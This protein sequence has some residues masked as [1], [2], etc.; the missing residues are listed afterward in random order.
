ML[1]GTRI[2]LNIAIDFTASNGHPDDED[3]LHNRDPQKNQY[4]QVIR[5][6][7]KLLHYYDSSKCVPTYGFGAKVK[8]FEGTWHA[9]ALNGDIYDPECNGIKGVEN[10]YRKALTATDFAGPTNFAGICKEI[11]QRLEMLPIS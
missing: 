2:C 10:A 7:G 6:V 3:S 8:G 4:L 5:E 9:F 1:G 11:N